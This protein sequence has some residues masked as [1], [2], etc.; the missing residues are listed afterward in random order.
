MKLIVQLVFVL[1]A[2]IVN[3]CVD[4]WKP[5]VGPPSPYRSVKRPIVVDDGALHTASSSK[6][7]ITFNGQTISTSIGDIEANDASGPVLTVDPPDLTS[8]L[9]GNSRVLG[10]DGEFGTSKFLTFF[11]DASAAPVSISF[12]ITFHLFLFQ[13][14]HDESVFFSVC[15]CFKKFD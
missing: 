7:V 2:V 5:I 14:N 12:D 15:H 9:E 10:G 13:A 6:S 4:G 3:D 11:G 1:G 8:D